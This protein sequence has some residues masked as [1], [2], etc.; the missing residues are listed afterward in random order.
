MVEKSKIY[1]VLLLVLMLFVSCTDDDISGK[2]FGILAN[3]DYQFV[4][5]DLSGYTDSGEVIKVIS[6]INYEYG[7]STVFPSEMSDGNY[8]FI[9]YSDSSDIIYLPEN[10][11][12]AENGVKIDSFSG[13][14]YMTGVDTTSLIVGLDYAAENFEDFM[15]DNC[16]MIGTGGVYDCPVQNNTEPNLFVSI[17]TLKNNYVTGEH[18]K[19]TDPPEDSSFTGFDQPII[20]HNSQDKVRSAQQ[21]GYSEVVP[22]A[23]INHDPRRSNN[24]Q[25]YSSSE[26]EIGNGF[27]I[28]LEEEALIVKEKELIETAKKN[29][30]KIESMSNLNP[31]KY[32]YKILST[33]SDDVEGKL[34]S[35]SNKLDSEKESVKNKIKNKLG[36]SG[37]ISITGNTVS[38]PDTIGVLADYKNTFNGFALDITP[39][40]ALELSK[41]SGIESITPNKIFKI[42]LFDSIPQINADIVW[43][44]NDSN[45]KPITGKGITI[46]IIDTGVDYNHTD[47]VGRV[48]GGFDFYDNDTD[49]MDEHGHGTHCAGIAA[50]N[51]TLKGVAPD[52]EIYA[53]RV[54]SPGGSCPNID[55]LNAIEASVDPNADGDFSDHLDVISISLGGPGDPDDTLSLAVDNAVSAGVIAVISAGNSGSALQTIGSPGTS[56]KAITVAAADSSN[57]IASFSSRG[58]VIWDD[59]NNIQQYMMKPDIA[60][61]GV[62]I[63]SAQW[64]DAWSYSECVDNEHTAISGTS[65]A[66]PHVSG[67]AALLLQANPELSPEE[68]KTILKA[69][70]RDIHYSV[71]E[72]GT[73]ILD[74]L[75]SIRIESVPNINTKMVESG[76]SLDIIINTTGNLSKVT[77]SY[78]TLDEIYWERWDEIVSYVN[79]TDSLNENFIINKE[80]YSNGLL[81]FRVR[82]EDSEG[83]A[84]DK[85]LFYE[86]NNFRIT[87][88]GDGEGFLIGNTADIQVEVNNNNYESYDIYFSKYI[89]RYGY[90]Q[91]QLLYQSN[92]TLSTGNIYSI[93][94]NALEDGKYAFYIDAKHTSGVS[95]KSKTFEN[96]IVMKSLNSGFVDT[97]DY[98]APFYLSVTDFNDENNILLLSDDRLE[99]GGGWYRPR[100]KIEKWNGFEKGDV[101]GDL[102]GSENS[103]FI[104]GNGHY[105]YSIYDDEN[106][107]SVVTY[108][109]TYN[110]EEN[111][112]SYRFL[113]SNDLNGNILNGWPNYMGYKV[114]S[115]NSG[116]YTMVSNGKLLFAGGYMNWTYLE[117]GN[118]SEFIKSKKSIY[119]TFD[120]EGNLLSIIEHY[121]FSTFNVSVS[122]R[123]D[124]WVDYASQFMIS[125]GDDDFL[126]IINKAQIHY[127]DYD[128]IPEYNI[129]M[130]NIATGEKTLDIEMPH[131]KS[132]IVNQFRTPVGYL[133][134]GES[135]FIFSVTEYPEN[136]SNYWNEVES[137][138]FICDI[139]GN[140]LNTTILQRIP[141]SITPFTYGGKTHFSIVAYTY[142]GEVIYIVNPEGELISEF[143]LKNSDS[144]EATDDIQLTGDFDNDGQPEF[145]I[146]SRPR[147][148]EGGSSYVRIYN[149]LGE[150]EKEIIIP[151]P[152]EVTHINDAVLSDYDSDG[153]LDLIVATSPTGDDSNYMVPQ[154]ANLLIFNLG[155][156][157]VE[158]NLDWIMYRG[159]LGR[160][161]CFNCQF[162]NFTIRPQSKIE[163]LGDKIING[164]MNLKIQKSNYNQWEDELF[165]VTNE[166]LSLPATGE[167]GNPIKLDVQYFNHQ[168]ITL[169]DVGEYRVI[170][171]FL[172]SSK[173]YNASWDF[174]VYEDQSIRSD[175]AIVDIDTNPERPISNESTGILIGI[176]NVGDKGCEAYSYY[177]NYGGDISSGKTVRT[178]LMPGETSSQILNHVFEE[179]GYHNITASVWCQDPESDYNNND[180][181]IEVFV[182]DPLPPSPFRITDCQMLQNIQNNLTADYKLIKNI[183]CSD[184]VNWN[185]GKGFKPIGNRSDKY[186]QPYGS[187]GRCTGVLP[188]AFSGT[189]DGNGYNITN[190]Y[191]NRTEYEIG[192]FAVS[193]GPS[194]KIKNVKLINAN[195]KSGTLSGG[196]VGTAYHGTKIYNISIKGSVEGNTAGG[197]VGNCRDCGIY[198]SG[199]DGSVYGKHTAG[200]VVG[201][202]AGGY[203]PHPMTPTIQNS[204]AQGSVYGQSISGGL[205]GWTCFGYVRYSYAAASINGGSP[206]G[207]IGSACPT[208]GGQTSTYWDIDLSGVTTNA[209]TGGEG[210]TTSEMKD[211]NTYTNWNFDT[212]WQSRCDGVDYPTLKWENTECHID[213]TCVD[214]DVTNEYLNGDNPY[215]SGTVSNFSS[216]KQK[217]SETWQDGNDEGLNVTSNTTAVIR[218]FNEIKDVTLG[219]VVEFG[220]VEISIDE[221]YFYGDH[222]LGN[223]IMVTITRISD[224]CDN[225]DL[226]EFICDS[227]NSFND[228][229]HSCENGCHEGACVSNVQEVTNFNL[230]EGQFTWRVN[231]I[232]NDWYVDDV[233]IDVTLRAAGGAVSTIYNS[234]CVE[235]NLLEGYN[236]NSIT[237]LVTSASYD[238]SNITCNETTAQCGNGIVEDGEECDEGNMNGIETCSN[239][240]INYEC[241]LHNKI[242]NPYYPGSVEYSETKYVDSCT[243]NTFSEYSCSEDDILVEGI[244][245][246]TCYN[247]EK[248]F[249]PSPGLITASTPVDLRTEL[250][251]ENNSDVV[252]VLI[253]KNAV[254]DSWAAVDVVGNSE[255]NL[256]STITN[257]TG[258][259]GNR[260]LIG[261]P[262][263]NPCVSEILGIPMNGSCGETFR[264][265][266]GNGFMSLVNNN[267][268]KSLIV[269]GYDANDTVT[270][271]RAFKIGVGIEYWFTPTTTTTW[272]TTTEATP[273]TI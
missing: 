82:V 184:T 266:Y 141:Q 234:S 180:M 48:V 173:M 2:A 189:F 202:M 132:K 194:T 214:S 8:I 14:I 11:Q 9:T 95:V 75:R 204:Y 78:R 50:G 94:V 61:P 174:S 192:M 179:T 106:E 208:R 60:A 76:D 131:N 156:E 33:Q 97:L 235:G 71:V 186:C 267:D 115:L 124:G 158:E 100:W 54:C 237:G 250:V 145:L 55:I 111:G 191:I 273:T 225:D 101:I 239:E 269:A 68:L 83:Y 65:M 91:S 188:N 119:K 38:D 238:I 255:L 272:T 138:L 263:V 114:S 44:M 200:G 122:N 144:T 125:D 59:V 84:Y 80:I 219:D 244:G 5:T 23:G 229:H 193:Y 43:R 258:C 56:R 253:G 25:T 226:V 130:Y 85:H 211:Y 242:D 118:I 245:D 223:Y 135:R 252:E 169:N 257:D 136:Y 162:D 222:N 89:D 47:L 233:P 27:I 19:I 139:N 216:P 196:L 4:M 185:D 45:G 215:A 20:Y 66:A 203:M 154:D 213:I 264:S 36:K 32:G 190:L 165:V 166:T 147:F 126:G 236:I 167:P 99:L 265:M 240:C 195:I 93:D 261:G 152:F 187:S 146:T 62:N 88:I 251:A 232:L 51:G 120:F 42:N 123:F 221:I 46:G 230:I 217:L 143:E 150:V 6:G 134:D 161:N 268:G 104:S 40:Q 243:N 163:N 87:Q 128:T 224:V 67:A 17:A 109:G 148:W 247:E 10:H 157:Y 207:I 121:P 22:I 69:G 172:T 105:G 98:L 24:E 63:C 110:T 201:N 153:F 140:I 64:E 113:S 206:G 102:Y 108:S 212:I 96:V 137:R 7:L 260:I 175:L 210:K 241:V 254:I 116:P 177:V 90:N 227:R 170:V 21:N 31:I 218:L 248:C 181:I 220:Y 58:P 160:T 52:A 155:Y 262:C 1:L 176:S 13:S 53:Y 81:I 86:N 127:D 39:E 142:H 159:D 73:G 183:D 133:E 168:N 41:I 270:I 228:E 70:A 49:P 30:E 79:L 178:P 246:C 205:I 198:S 28:K 92:S 199:F 107:K 37:F 249:L 151:T 34:E 112:N 259:D 77:L 72:Q 197:I 149:I 3:S 35:Y 57:N 171:E 271:A 209:G 164:I 129:L 182:D 74:V 15:V 29:E 231:A 18:I 12:P 26:Y 256:Y 117:N 103:Y 16:V